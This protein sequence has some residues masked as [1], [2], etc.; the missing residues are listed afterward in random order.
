MK[1]QCSLFRFSSVVYLMSPF[2]RVLLSSDLRRLEE[3]AQ[4]LH[5]PA[6]FIKYVLLIPAFW[7]FDL[8]YLF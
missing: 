2:G 7:P 8:K 6:V 3:M 1:L 4:H 5:L